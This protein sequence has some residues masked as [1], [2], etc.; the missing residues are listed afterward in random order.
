MID[1]LVQIPVYFKV[2]YYILFFLKAG[3]NLNKIY[4]N[5]E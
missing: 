4:D 2:L 1:N 5:L 3:T